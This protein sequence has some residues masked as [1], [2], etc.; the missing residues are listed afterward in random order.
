VV[1]AV[2]EIEIV[3]IMVKVFTLSGK[4]GVEINPEITI[5]RD[6]WIIVGPFPI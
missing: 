5:I 4:N 1:V 3:E 2:K 6:V